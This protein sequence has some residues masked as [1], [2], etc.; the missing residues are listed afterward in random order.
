MKPINMSRS[1]FNMSRSRSAKRA[2][3]DDF[4]SIL[5][6]ENI[7][8]SQTFPMWLLLIGILLIP[9][10]LNIHLSGDGLKFTPGRAAIAL[11]LLPSLS[12]L[13]RPSRHVIAA[14]VFVFLASLWMVGSRIP[15]DGLNQSAM[16][17]T[18][19]LF[20]GYFVGRAYF[21]GP[22]ALT[23]FLRIFKVIIFLVISI[24]VLDPL[25]G[26][27][28]VQTAVAMIAQTPVSI[29]NQERFGIV[30][31][32]STIEMAELYGTVC[33]VA[34]S[35]FLFMESSK[36]A[37]CFW[38]GLSFFG[39]I[40]SLS[41]GPLLAFTIIIS[42]FVYDRVFSRYAWRWKLI[43]AILA[44]FLLIVSV[45]TN[46]P[47]SWVLSHLTLDAST[48]YFRMYVFDYMFQQIALSPLVGY[49]F[50]SVGGD[51]FLSTV[52]VDS[53]WLVC[54]IRYGIPMIG[55]FLCANLAS[56]MSLTS[57]SRSRSI[58]PF[59]TE[60]ATGF[61]QTVIAFMLIGITVHFW[62]ATWML[63]AV[64]IGIRGSIKEWQRYGG[65][66]SYAWLTSPTPQ[67]PTTRAN[68]QRAASNPIR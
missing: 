49:G 22:P 14:D 65:H 39:C 24:A 2:S 37:K 46:R 42:F 40:L 19:E 47:I 64:C 44:L 9:A 7:P 45:V 61:T 36:S 59:M 35:I 3:R 21:Y 20:G 29:S 38:T 43:T 41:S 30:R 32:A 28:V 52:T 8:Q 54:A 51:E 13:F 27:N 11:L 16:A 15:Y 33:C 60:A 56:F 26:L 53:V 6:Y 10:G 68:S 23:N 58:E 50:S 25:L 5:E 34:G 18:I 48:G 31:A 62:N 4:V 57:R 55:F 67:A 17:S 1:T 12:I 63:W 66:R